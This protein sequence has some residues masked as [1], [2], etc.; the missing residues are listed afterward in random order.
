LCAAGF[1]IWITVKTLQTATAPEFWSLIGI[2]ASGVLV[3]LLVRV[4]LRPDFF[5]TPRESA[6]RQRPS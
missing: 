1:L 6:P 2:T 3:M 4:I 5:R